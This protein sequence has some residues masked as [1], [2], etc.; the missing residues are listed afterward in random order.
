ML[1]AE[2]LLFRLARAFSATELAH[3][4][5]MKEALS[6]RSRCDRYRR[7]QAGLVLKAADRFAVSLRDADVLD[8]GCNNGSLTIQYAALEPRRIIGVDIDAAAV[9]A[10]RQDRPHE[11]VEYKVGTPASLPV[12]DSSV[13]VILCYD[14]FEHVSKP[15]IILDECRRVLR[16]G[17]RMLIGTWGW[18]HPFAPHLWATMP[19]PWAHVLVSERTLLRACRR[20]YHASWYTPNFYDFDADGR[21][22]ADAYGEESISTDYLNKFLVRDFERVFARS[23][24]RWNVTLDPFGSARWTRPLLRVPLVR[25]FLHGYLWAVLE[26][27]RG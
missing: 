9:A 24:L 10:A 18:F 5:S 3:S 27:P 2:L 7:D 26:K 23:G 11:K 15:S 17:G 21:R 1:L 22:K 19:V 8:L 13:D 12:D 25:E 16:P 20:V 14:V 4:A 6:D